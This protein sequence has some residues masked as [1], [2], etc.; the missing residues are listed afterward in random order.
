MMT[1]RCGSSHKII[2][3]TT[4]P[5]TSTETKA[6]QNKCTT[7]Y[8]RK[9]NAWSPAPASV[10]V[11]GSMRCLV[12]FSGECVAPRPGACVCGGRCVLYFLCIWCVRVVSRPVPMCEWVCALL[13]FIQGVRG[14]LSRR[15]SVCFVL[16]STVYLTWVRN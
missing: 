8:L 10:C 14:L 11:C 13:F 3:I 15:P 9:K 16:R 1:R 2:Q 4:T 12:Y 5:H 7:T 6:K